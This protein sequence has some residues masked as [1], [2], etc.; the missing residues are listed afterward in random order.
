MTMEELEAVLGGPPG[1]YRT[2][3]VALDSR[4]GSGRYRM[5]PPVRHEWWQGDDGNLSVSF[6]KQDR[7]VGYDYL[8][9]SRPTFLD[10]VRRWLGL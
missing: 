2:G 6:D 4:G 9:G 5:D 1:D 7:V 8:H 10:K 3:E